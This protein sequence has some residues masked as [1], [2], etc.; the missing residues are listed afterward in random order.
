MEQLL[1]IPMPQIDKT[2]SSGRQSERSSLFLSVMQTKYL[3]EIIMVK[4]TIVCSFM[5]RVFPAITRC[6]QHVQPPPQMDTIIIRFD[7]RMRIIYRT[8]TR[9]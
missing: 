9:K 8:T 7:R 5:R 1:V 6:A 2:T 3:A 4:T